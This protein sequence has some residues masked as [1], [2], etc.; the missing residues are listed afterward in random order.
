MKIAIQFNKIFITYINVLRYTNMRA[1]LLWH[2]I[3]KLRLKNFTPYFSIV[4]YLVTIAALYHNV[5][6]NSHY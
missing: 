3:N 2:N 1:V 5:N 6:F 4:I